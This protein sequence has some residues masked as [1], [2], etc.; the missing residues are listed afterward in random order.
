[1]WKLNHQLNLSKNLELHVFTY[2]LQIYLRPQ[3]KL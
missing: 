2:I 3:G 1:M